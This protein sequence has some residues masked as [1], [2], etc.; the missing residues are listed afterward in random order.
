MRKLQQVFVCYLAE[1]PDSTVKKASFLWYDSTVEKAFLAQLFLIHLFAACR[2]GCTVCWLYGFTTSNGAF[3][4]NW[5]C[6]ASMSSILGASANSLQSDASCIA[7]TDS[8]RIASV[9]EQV[10]GAKIS[11]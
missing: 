2:V 10:A 5:T 1:E 4:L 3:Y 7:S 6:A 11:S 8:N 9:T